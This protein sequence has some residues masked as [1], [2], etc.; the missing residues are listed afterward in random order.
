[1]IGT[2]H[3]PWLTA[4]LAIILLGDALM[5]IRPPGFIQNC[6]D[7]VNFPRD[8]WWALICIKVLAAAGLALG[9]KYPG[10]GIAANAGV[11]AYFVA[12]SYA[13]YRAKFMKQEFWLNCLGMLGFSIVVL[14]VSYAM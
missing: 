2:P 6:L 7:G 5:S 14:V 10:I 11:I 3:F 8:W 9:L 12:A 13:H 1:M 4:L